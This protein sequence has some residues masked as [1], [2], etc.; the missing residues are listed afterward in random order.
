MT[1][2]ARKNLEEVWIPYRKSFFYIAN[3]IR[4]LVENGIDVKL[5]NF[6]LCTVDKSFWT[7]CEKSISDNKVRFAEECYSCKY[8][9]AC[10][11]IFAGTLQLERD[12]LRPIL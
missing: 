7:L 12:E 9:G 4:L 11:G 5:Y 6:P 1:G 3:A 8:K 10:S 2:T